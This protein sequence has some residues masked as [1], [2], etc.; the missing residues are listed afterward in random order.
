MKIRK[1]LS[2]LTVSLIAVGATSSY[3]A[4][5][6]DEQWVTSPE[7]RKFVAL[8]DPPHSFVM[9][10]VAN[11]NSV[12]SHLY[13]NYFASNPKD[14]ERYICTNTTDGKCGSAQDYAFGAV[15]PTCSSGSD[16]NCVGSLTAYGSDGKALTGSFTEYSVPNHFNNFPATPELGIPQGATGGI[17]TIAGAPHK[18]GNHYAV[19]VIAEGTANRG[20]SKGWP[21]AYGTLSARIVPISIQKTTKRTTGWGTQQDNLLRPDTKANTR[22]GAFYDNNEG[23]RCIAPYGTQDDQCLVSHAFPENIRFKLSVQLPVAPLG[24]IHGRLIDPSVDISKTGSSYT[25]TVEANPARIPSV[26]H[27]AAWSQLPDS[28]QK[29]WAGLDTTDCSNNACGQRSSNNYSA[30]IG[31]QTTFIMA[32]NFGAEAL[33]Q[34]KLYLPLVKDTAIAS[35]STWS[36]RT[37]PSNELSAANGCFT[38]GDGV[39]GIVTTNASAYSAGPPEFKDGVLNY[40]VAAPHFNRDGTVFKGDYTLVLDSKVARC[41]YKFSNAPIQATISVIND[42]GEQSVTSTTVSES[43]GWLR[44]VARNFEFS[45]PTVQVKLS[46]DAPAPVVVPTPIAIPEPAPSASSTP[47]AAPAPIVVPVVAAKKTTITCIKGKTTKT[48]TAVKPTCPTGYKRK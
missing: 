3:A 6:E 16:I 38:A 30:P 21:A 27:T 17:W 37:L 12:V 20:G 5:F 13:A 22:G 28:I 2:I 44:L 10:E 34:L 29:Y 18:F 33:K 23:F 19:F 35:P 46:Q 14:F 7:L 42:K 25:I 15:F 24:W 41:L 8:T 31:Q 45:S 36:W 47:V 32:S 26:F 4:D 9:E 40:Q 11:E 48:I 1:F 43:N 39:K